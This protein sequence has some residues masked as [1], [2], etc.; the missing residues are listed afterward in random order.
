MTLVP[1]FAFYIA[2]NQKAVRTLLLLPLL[3]LLR[4]KCKMKSLILRKTKCHK[5]NS[6]VVYLSR[7][8]S[9]STEAPNNRRVDK[10]IIS[11]SRNNLFMSSS[12]LLRP[13]FINI[14][15]NKRL[16]QK[17]STLKYFSNNIRTF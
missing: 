9:P 2:F 12:G 3:L 6:I 8:N 11:L 16:I 4:S 5:F 14:P 7:R 1:P 13:T 10:S 15:L 17:K